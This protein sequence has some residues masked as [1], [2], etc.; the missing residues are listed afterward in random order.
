MASYYHVASED[1]QRPSDENHYSIGKLLKQNAG[2]CSWYNAECQCRSS[3]DDGHARRPGIRDPL[4]FHDELPA[5]DLSRPNSLLCICR[6]GRVLV[7]VVEWIPQKHD[8]CC[9]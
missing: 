9:L 3:L 1:S 4:D 8:V 2:P 5:C 6:D 7:R